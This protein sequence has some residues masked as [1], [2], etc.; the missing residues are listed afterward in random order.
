MGRL[1]LLLIAI[2]GSTV[3]TAQ[4]ATLLLVGDSTIDITS[5]IRYFRDDS[6]RYT[7][8]EILSAEADS[9]FAQAIESKMSTTKRHNVFWGRVVIENALPFD[10]PFFAVAKK[11]AISTDTV[12]WYFLNPTGRWQRQLRGNLVED[13]YKVYPA[14]GFI[15]AAGRQTVLYF[16]MVADN[17]RPAIS[18]AHFELKPMA[19]MLEQQRQA[20]LFSGWFYGILTTIIV[21]CTVFGLF[22]RERNYLLL[23]L[24][25]LLEVLYYLAADGI[26]GEFLWTHYPFVWV[27]KVGANAFGPISVCLITLFSV[28]FLNTRSTVP[29]LHRMI[30]TVALISAVLGLLMPYHDWYQFFRLISNYIAIA[31]LA[32]LIVAGAYLA[33]RKRNIAGVLFL[34]CFSISFICGIIWQL[35]LNGVIPETSLVKTINQIGLVIAAFLFSVAVGYNALQLRRKQRE[36][37]RRRLLMEAENAR[38]VKEQNVMLEEQVARRTFQLETEKKKSDDL[39]LNI[40]PS[41]VANELKDHGTAAARLYDNVTVLFTDFVNFTKAGEKLS[42]QELV[43]ELNDCFKA[44]DEIITRHGLEKIKTIGDAY[45]A[46]AGLPRPLP[47]HACNA[48]A[49]AFDI[50][51][52]LQRRKEQKE[53]FDVRIG[54]HSGPVVAGIVGVKKFAY[55][56]WG[57]TVNTAARMEQSGAVGKINISHATYDLIRNDYQC[58]YRGEVRAKNK[59]EMKM[60]FVERQ[61]HAAIP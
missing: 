33:F 41:E 49:A 22:F 58:S 31:W 8:A 50:L 2:L 23:A 17:Y 14:P 7:F 30:W 46:V 36:T 59:G 29:L 13:R 54:V 35:Y 1:A 52:F 16:R 60:Y 21:F 43:D 10:A 51:S 11:G 20:R 47:Q 4:H 61:Q 32:A 42:P 15:L 18:N 37:E 12:E 3:A 19:L 5:H 24:V 6:D 56:I 25:G 26:G 34:S 39:L 44:F 45:L 53:S 27:D 48:V 28:K 9:L 40:L 55:D 38:L 57:D